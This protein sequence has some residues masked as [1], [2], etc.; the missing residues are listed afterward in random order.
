MTMLTKLF[1][2]DD[3]GRLGDH[4][5]WLAHCSIFDHTE[6][7]DAVCIVLRDCIPKFYDRLRKS[8]PVETAT[9]TVVQ[10]RVMPVNAG[11]HVELL[12]DMFRSVAPSCKVSRVETI[13]NTKGGQ[14]GATVITRCAVDVRV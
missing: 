7:K 1:G 14:D 5:T 6:D 10:F 4:K 9:P 13:K 2:P 12:Q 8:F 3:C 11:L